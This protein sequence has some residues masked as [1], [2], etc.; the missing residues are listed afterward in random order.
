MEAI[1]GLKHIWSPPGSVH[2]VQA[3]AAASHSVALKL[4]QGVQGVGP[5]LGPGLGPGPG[6]GL[7][8]PGRPSAPSRELTAEAAREKS[9]GTELGPAGTVQLKMTVWGGQ[10][11]VGSGAD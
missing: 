3:S 1:T 5:G 2:R 4:S 10:N 7:S 8:P 11:G 9:A 6:A